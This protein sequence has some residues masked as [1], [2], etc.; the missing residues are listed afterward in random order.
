MLQVSLIVISLCLLFRWDEKNCKGIPWLAV[1]LMACATLTK[2]PV[3]S[4]FPCLG[5]GVYQLL[6]GRSFGKAFFS[7]LGIGLLSLIPLGIWFWAAY[8]QDG[9]AFVNLM[10]EE[11]T[12][13]FFRKMSYAS[14]ENPLWYNFLTIIWGWVPWTLVLLI[15]LFGLK[16]K[17]YVFCRKVLPLAN[18]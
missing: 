11:N 3:G 15:S 18:V 13:R 2:G 17:R 16:W 12:G 10:L 7:L 4:I 1:L 5:I 9:E 14:H 8:Q 6:R